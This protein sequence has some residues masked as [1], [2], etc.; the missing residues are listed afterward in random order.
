MR[1]NGISF[2]FLLAFGGLVLAEAG[3]TPKGQSPMFNITTKRMDDSVEVRSDRDKTVFAIKSPFGISQA[4]IER[5]GEKWPDVV[6]LRLHL[7]GLESFRVSNAKVT[8]DA[9]V[10]SHDDKQRVRV[11]KDG[12]EK[13]LLDSRS[14]FW[15]D[16]RMVGGDGKPAKEI[17]LKDGYF[18]IHL[19]GS[20]FKDNPKSITANW[21]D[22]YR[23]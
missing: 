1:V 17:P 4:V 5:A 6:V 11:W 3:D 13:A 15:M 19:P 12:D 21:I 8:L 2:A 14:P 18:E 20:F 7:K 10:S 22:F 9:A 23:N 16:I